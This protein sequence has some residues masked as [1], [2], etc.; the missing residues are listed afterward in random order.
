M[1]INKVPPKTT[2]SPTGGGRVA[3]V[4]P[5]LDRPK[6]VV[7][8]PA[9]VVYRHTGVLLGAQRPAR[10]TA[11][12]IQE[13]LA[14]LVQAQV[15]A[16]LALQPLLEGDK[17]SNTKVNL[18]LRIAGKQASVCTN[19][20]NPACKNYA[21]MY[22]EKPLDIDQLSD[23]IYVFSQMAQALG[24]SYGVVL[25]DDK[26][27]MLLRATLPADQGEDPGSMIGHFR[28][29]RDRHDYP[30]PTNAQWL[31]DQLGMSHVIGDGHEWNPADRDRS[32]LGEADDRTA[33]Q[34]ALAQL[35]KAPGKRGG[36]LY[37]TSEQPTQRLSD[38]ERQAD[39]QGV[40]TLAIA[41]G[42]HADRISRGLFA[43][44][45]KAPDIHGLRD[46]LSAH[47]KQLLEPK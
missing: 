8:D 31:K 1:P 17:A 25:V 29:F 15:E 3:S 19:C 10:E 36:L 16:A 39:A 20:G 9:P 2:P 40:S 35:A 43:N 5:V 14:P 30:D 12:Q 4:K 38:I 45:V 13:R 37:I 33:L 23:S 26:D 28:A 32:A 7:A 22:R 34:I 41:M 46:E 6:P 11:L 47:L 24:I 27:V 44:T 21:K 42:R 18:V